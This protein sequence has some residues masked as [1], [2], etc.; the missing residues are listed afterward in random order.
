V[1]ARLRDA[2]AEHLPTHLQGIND[3]LEED[4]SELVLPAPK[5]VKICIPMSVPRFNGRGDLPALR[6][7]H[8]GSRY[9]ADGREQL[10][11]IRTTVVL[12]A[13]LPPF[14]ADAGKELDPEEVL[15][16]AALHYAH[17]MQLTLSSLGQ[18]EG[19]IG[20]DGVME[21]VVTGERIDEY[22]MDGQMEARMAVA[23]LSV[24][25]LQ[26][27]VYGSPY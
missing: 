15:A 4:G 9:E 14:G 20:Q 2:L 23:T 1:L 12:S 7:Q 22:E 6:V 10:G 26:E 3:Q 21:I 13:V 8:F 19:P 17:A 25:V 16:V 24:E 5:S 27:A 18:E 11:T